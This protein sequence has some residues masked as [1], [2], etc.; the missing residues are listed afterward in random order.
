MM[1]E[2]RNRIG[3]KYRRIAPFDSSG[4]PVKKR[5]ILNRKALKV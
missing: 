1:P 3:R 5:G 4:K 2:S